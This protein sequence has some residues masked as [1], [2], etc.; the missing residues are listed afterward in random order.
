MTPATMRAELVSL[1]RRVEALEKSLASPVAEVATGVSV[2]DIVDVTA[3]VFGVPVAA[4]MSARRA[5]ECV[6]PRQVAMHL[7]VELLNLS[8]TAVGRRFSRDHST[9]LYAHRSIAARCQ[10][11]PLLAMRVQRA[12]LA[13]TTNPSMKDA[14]A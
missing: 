3:A 6:V 7:A 1:R 5:R 4:V 11:E 13:I 2:A 12:R 8:T 10:R 9:V 14:A